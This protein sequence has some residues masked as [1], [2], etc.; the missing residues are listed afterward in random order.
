MVT[1]IISGGQAGADRAA[2]DFALALTIPHGGWCPKGRL[3]VDGPLHSKY[4]L[5]ETSSS[6][7]SQRTNFNIRDSDGTVVFNSG[8]LSGGTSL[9]VKTV[10][11]LGKSLV[12]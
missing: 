8:A 3:A 7:Y 9:T 5:T 11:E 2:V 6:G 4:R 10:N 1:K 12:W